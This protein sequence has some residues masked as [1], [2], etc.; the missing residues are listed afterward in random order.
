MVLLCQGLVFEPK[1]GVLA[2]G[3]F[4]IFIIVMVTGTVFLLFIPELR[5]Y[6][7]R[8]SGVKSISISKHTFELLSE[9]I[10]NRLLYIYSESR[11]TSDGVLSLHPFP[12]LITKDEIS[13][14][15][16]QLLYKGSP[17]ME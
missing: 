5:D 3:I 13:E 9:D 11:I 7:K 1:D 2:F 14:M 17:S 6:F 15:R 16:N 4:G 12:N 10:K 8:G